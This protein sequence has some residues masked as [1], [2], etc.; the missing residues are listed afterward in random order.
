MDSMSREKPRV[1]VYVDGSNIFYAQKKLGWFLDWN[2]VR[3]HL[4][5]EWDVLSI[6]YYTGV[7][8]GDEKMKSFLRYLDAVGISPVTKPLKVIKISED[9][10]LNK[11]HNYSDMHKSDCDVE[12]AIDMLLERTG[13]DQAVLFSGDSDFRYLIKKLNDLGKRVTVFSS[14]KTISWEIKLEAS[15]YIYLEDIRD[16]IER[17]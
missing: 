3:A 4:E 10:P 2:K 11:L 7:K 14:R 9:H 17:K 6:K 8:S 5:K 12:I 1:N 15:R 13:I 16:E